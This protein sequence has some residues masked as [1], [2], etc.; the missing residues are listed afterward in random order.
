VALWSVLL[1]AIA[2]T[3]V[4]RHAPQEPGHDR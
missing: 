3:L 1:A 4:Q 2:W